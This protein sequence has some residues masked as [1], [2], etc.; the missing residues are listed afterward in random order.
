M[1]KKLLNKIWIFIPI[2]IFIFLYEMI[3][4]DEI[5][6]ANDLVA[7]K[8]IS[9]W[10]ESVKLSS[11]IFPQWFPNLFS[12]MP[13]YGGYIYTPG[14]PL[15]I[16]L[17]YVFFN[18][19]LKIWFYLTLGGLGL[20]CFLRNL[21]ISI[22]GSLFSS[23][24]SCLTPYTFGLI[25]A[26]HMNKIYAMSFMPWVLLAAFQV[27]DRPKLKSILFLSLVASFQLWVN[28]PQIVYY[29]WMVIGFYWIWGIIYSIKNKILSGMI[30][31]NQIFALFASLFISILIV[32]D[33]YMDIFEFQSHSNR[34][35]K[36]VMDQTGQTNTG[37]DWNY[38]TQWSFH[39]KE[40]ISFLFP[41]HYGLQNFSTRDIK[42]AAYWGYMPFT[43]STHYLG[44]VC[45]IFAILGVLL[46]K[47]EKLELFFWITTLLVLITGFGKFF[48]ILYKPFYLFFPFFS[49]FR[50]PSMIYVLLAITV[51]VLAAI[52]FDLFLEKITENKTRK[53]AT[54]LVSVI[55]GISIFFLMFGEYVID[56]SHTKDARY[57]PMIITQMQSLR[58]ELFHKGLILALSISLGC[59]GLIWSLFK[60]KINK[61]NF[62]YMI[63]ALAMFDLWVVNVE[64]LNLKPS[65]QMDNFFRE[66]AL[67]KYLKKQNGHFRIYPADDFNSNKYSYWNLE[68][69]GGYHPI[70]LRIYQDLI[71]ANGFSRT[72]ILDMLN[73]KYILTKKKI[74][75][76]NFFPI[77]GMEGIYENKNVLPKAWIVGNVKTVESQT[78][79]LME[80][81][82]ND[83]NP[84]NTAVVYNYTGTNHVK[85]AHGEIIINTRSEN[86]IEIT[87]NSETGGLLVLSEIFYKPGWKATINDIQTPIFQTNHVLRSIEIPK[88]ECKIMVRYDDNNWKRVRTF[89]R[90]CFF[91][92]LLL[93]GIFFWKENIKIRLQK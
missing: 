51:P 28:H 40:T 39:P 67:I 73:V 83:F 66:D 22:L 74:N 93:F 55:I 72:H 24:V 81:L 31:R 4:F 16:I 52:G 65:K 91:L 44:L 47:P 90:F 53:N 30:I 42:S 12:G 78:E 68:S 84:K 57:N 45:I 59:L 5:P 38:A 75:S 37:T 70:K 36:S 64:F 89:S 49:K 61:L 13:S 6:M 80:I 23:L 26:G 34:G 1:G 9:K 46:K 87:S 33:P 21:N 88:G 82:S 10:K 32:S 25:N 41:Y 77:D 54:I 58:I 85:N 62:G 43:Q 3:L 76:P 69:I 19:G 14:D 79:S 15:K 18:R 63:I 17:D 48:P 60:N 27:M 92:V 56:F 50:V 20:F 2:I 35:A 29:T 71:D 11:N 7:H 86:N 8:P